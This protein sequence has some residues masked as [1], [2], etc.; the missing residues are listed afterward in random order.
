MGVKGVEG[1][2]DRHCQTSF[3]IFTRPTS[4]QREEKTDCDSQ[5]PAVTLVDR[6]SV[7]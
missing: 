7:T 1:K 5:T 2:R 3:E 4:D 6:D